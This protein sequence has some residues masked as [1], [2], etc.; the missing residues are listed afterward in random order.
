M[1]LDATEEIVRAICSDKFDG[2]RYSPSLFKG[3]NTSVSRLSV[4]PLEEHWDLF[5]KNVQV[6]PERIL[7]QIGQIHIGAMQRVGE[8]HLT[9]L[10]LTVEPDPLDWNPGHAVMP[11]NISKGLSKKITK[12]ME[13]HSIPTHLQKA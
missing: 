9:K 7:V 10:Q 5:Q 1:A 13:K 8:E 3:E 6:P 12:K 11:Q 2:E 4:I